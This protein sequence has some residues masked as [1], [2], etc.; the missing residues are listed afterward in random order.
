MA[1]DIQFPESRGRKG[2]GLRRVAEVHTEKSWKDFTGTATIVL[3][4]RVKD[5]SRI[6]RDGLF[7][8]GDPVVIKFG[9]GAG[10]LPTEFVGYLSAVEDG[11]PYVLRCE[12]EMYRL[13]R[14][15]ATVSKGSITL[16][17]LLQAIAPGYEVECPEVALGAVRYTDTA[18]IAVLENLKKELGFHAYFVGKVL[19]CID[20]NSQDGQILKVV[21]ERNSVSDSINRKKEVEEKMLVKFRSLQRNGKYITIEV[22]DKGGTV[23]TRNW[24]YLTETE[25]QVRAKRII[26]LAKAQGF[27]GT[28]TLFG[29]PRAEQ[30]MKVD[31]KSLFFKSREG[32]YHIDKVVKDFTS[33]GLRQIITLGTKAE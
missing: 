17:E 28:V 31:F 25:I 8:V 30:G 13:K 9:Y 20:G 4:R 24:P 11:I 27:D 10:E 32:L 1:A 2:F 5:F 18:P 26:E 12:D 29:I 23:Q 33:D 15:S 22:G 6:E 14:G 19:H 21:L 3:P 7:E 16:K